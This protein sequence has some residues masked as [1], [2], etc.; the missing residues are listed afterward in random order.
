M[1]HQYHIFKI[2]KEKDT[3]RG[4]TDNT[5]VSGGATY[6]FLSSKTSISDTH[7]NNLES[8]DLQTPSKK[9][10]NAHKREH[11][12][13]SSIGS[14]SFKTPSPSKSKFSFSRGGGGD[15]MISPLLSS[16]KKQQD[17]STKSTASTD[18]IIT[19]PFLHKLSS[20]T[21]NLLSNH[22]TFPSASMLT[23]QLIQQNAKKILTM[24]G[25]TMILQKLASAALYGTYLQKGDSV[26]IPFQWIKQ[27]RGLIIKG[28][29]LVLFHRTSLIFIAP[30][31]NS[32]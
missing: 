4:N 26:N 23:L 24:K 6:Q 5:Q 3:R 31:V 13:Q 10:N 19:L 30:G 21:A 20:S 16:T 12:Q 11:L 32:F 25:N 18:N 28:G 15:V 7:S 14:N 17:T 1:L 27:T 2:D 29:G 22:F 8:N 9:D